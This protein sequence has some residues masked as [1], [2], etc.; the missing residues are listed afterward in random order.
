MLVSLGRTLRTIREDREM[1]QAEVANLIG[2]SQ[3]TLC[4]LETGH[5]GSI[6]L[7]TLRRFADRL[8]LKDHEK[9]RLGIA[10]FSP[11]A[12]TGRTSS[13]AVVFRRAAHAEK[14]TP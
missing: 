13:G 12:T 8:E 10:A 6:A 1:T 11:H 3:V 2:I 14:G 5:Q 4:R 9:A 7:A